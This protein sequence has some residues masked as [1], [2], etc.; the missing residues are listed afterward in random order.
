[1]KYYLIAGERSGDLHGSNLLESLKK[2]DMQAQFRGIGGEQMRSAGLDLV[3]PYSRLA[4]M[5]FWEVFK[6][7]FTIGKYLKSTQM[8]LMNYQPDVLILIDYPGFNLRIAKFAKSNGI[9][10]F[11]YIS[12]KIWAWNTKRAYKIKK[13]VDKM[14]TILPFE[15]DFYK[16]FDITVDYVGN[17]V[18]DAVNNYS[19]D[20]NYCEQYNLNPTKTIAVLP[21]S[22]K[23][24]VKLFTNQIID[25]ANNLKGYVFTVSQVDNLPSDLYDS[26]KKISNIRLIKGNTYDLLKNSCAA[27]VTSGTATLETAVLDIPQ[28]VC[29]RMSAITYAIAKRIVKVKFISLVNLIMDLEVVKELIQEELNTENLVLQLNRIIDDSDERS[30]MLSEYKLMRDLLGYENV[31]DKTAKLMYSY[32]IES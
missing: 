18:M 8:D 21:G 13:C 12:P 23:Q 3:V 6:N 29:Y 30:K 20:S 31:S 19:F 1:M 14:F 24:E 28:V 7:I 15:S 10:V 2:L 16:N 17:P 27:I 32:L 5:G 26:L 22:R 4:F 9:K 11:Y 25:L